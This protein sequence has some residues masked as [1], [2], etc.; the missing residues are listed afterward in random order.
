MPAVPA[1]APEHC[2][3]TESTDAGKVD[4]CAGCPNQAICASGAGA[5][6]PDPA[7]ADIAGRLAPVRHK[8][9][10]LSGKGGVGKS[11]VT[12][13][14]AFALS[15]PQNDDD[16]DEDDDDNAPHVG[17]LDVDITGPSVPIL[18][19]VADQTVHQTATGWTPVP[20]DERLCCMSIAF[21]LPNRDDAVIWRGPKK[22]GLIKQFLRDVD[23]GPLDYLLVDTPPGT[24]DEHLSLVTYLKDAGIDGAVLVTTPQEVSL[25]DVRKEIAFCRK[26][27]VPIVGVVENMAGFVC[28]GCH[29]E[30]VIFAPTTGGAKAMCADLE[31]PF[32]GSIPLDPRIARSADAGRAF[33]DEFPDSPATLAYV[34]IVRQ[35]R[36][37]FPSASA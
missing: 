1:D 33:M 23:W 7:I 26:V 35:I 29:K 21:L 27:G 19:G 8:L 24:S 28:P 25:Q 11:T 18:L 22:N 30:S 15:A 36:E 5:T 13:N 9:L 14:L 4:A 37:R 3:G 32:L 12:A 2:P 10:V 20:V 16:N 17:V 31:V 34:D 6:G